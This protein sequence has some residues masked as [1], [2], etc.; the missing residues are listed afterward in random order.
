MRVRLVMLNEEGEELV[1]TIRGPSSKRL[2]DSLE[3]DFED[4]GF[5][6]LSRFEV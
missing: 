1:A 2:A 5:R 6:R 3:K 4:R